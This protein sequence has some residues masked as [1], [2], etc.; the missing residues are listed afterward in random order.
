MPGGGIFEI[1][2]F[3][4][5]FKSPVTGAKGTRT[6]RLDPTSYPKKLAIYERDTS[7]GAGI[8]KFDNAKLVICLAHDPAQ[9]VNDFSAHAGSKQTLM[10]L[11]RF[12]AGETQIPGYNA[13]LPTPPPMNMTA[14]LPPA[15]TST[16]PS[17]TRPRRRR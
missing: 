7:R 4:I 3:T 9:P 8:Y 6:F 12:E 13:T 15:P 10:V 5:L 16:P 1:V 17:P 14:M 11:E 2:D